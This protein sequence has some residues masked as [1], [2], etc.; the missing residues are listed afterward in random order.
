M[1]EHENMIAAA[2]QA[3]ESGGVDMAKIPCTGC[4][5]ASLTGVCKRFPPIY[6]PPHPVETPQGVVMTNA[7]WSFPPAAQRCGEWRKPDL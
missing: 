2:K 3:A 6:I 7:N 1:S 5:Y 4:R